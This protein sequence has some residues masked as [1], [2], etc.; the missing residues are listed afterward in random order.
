MR[1]D[2][3]KPYQG[4]EVVK[5]KRRHD[6]PA[7]DCCSPLKVS[8]D[9]D[10]GPDQSIYRDAQSPLD[11][12]TIYVERMIDGSQAAKTEIPEDELFRLHYPLDEVET[13]LQSAA[14][15]P[16]DDRIVRILPSHEMAHVDGIALVGYEPGQGLET[17]LLLA[18]IQEPVAN[19]GV[20]GFEGD[21]GTESRDNWFSAISVNRRH[22]AATE[23]TTGYL[24][25]AAQHAVIIERN[26]LRKRGYNLAIEQEELIDLPPV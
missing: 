12:K 2:E 21:L 14:A 24:R 23:M 5:G 7:T 6:Y 25:N 8:V 9:T 17:D 3:R 4:T 19:A 11:P 15:V 1:S 26:L 13:V 10:W 22:K 18:P 20:N 16:P